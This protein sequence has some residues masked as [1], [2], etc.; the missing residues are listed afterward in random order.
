VN[1]LSYTRRLLCFLPWMVFFL[2]IGC[3]SQK[4]T[5]LDDVDKLPTQV[6]GASDMTIAE[7]QTRIKKS[8]VQVITIG[9]D[10]LISIPSSLLFPD[11][12]PQLTWASYQLLNDI[13]CYL[14]QFRKISVYVR[15]FSSQYVSRTREH[16]LTLARAKAVGDYLWGQGVQSRFIFTQGLGSDKPIGVFKKSGDDSPNSRVEITFRRV[17]A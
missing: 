16:A 10:Y 17:L 4:T 13:A 11:E 5:T 9:D 15:A 12:S 2:V 8:G 14:Q 3:Q 6:F 7:L 1:C